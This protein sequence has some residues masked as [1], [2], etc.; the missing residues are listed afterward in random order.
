MYGAPAGYDFEKDQSPTAQRI[1]KE[2]NDM[3]AAQQI[4][5]N[6]ASNIEHLQLDEKSKRELYYTY[7]TA[8][9]TYFGRY[10]T[11]ENQEKVAA[12]IE[13]YSEGTD[14]TKQKTMYDKYSSAAKDIISG[15]EEE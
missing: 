1:V 9:S 6:M 10:M 13:Q 8:V 2:Y 12:K 11:P 7:Y 3:T 14:P 4:A 15:K 5:D